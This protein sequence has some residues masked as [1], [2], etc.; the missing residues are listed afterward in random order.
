MLI[1]RGFTTDGTGE[2]LTPFPGSPG[3]GQSVDTDDQ[4]ATEVPYDNSGSGL[5]AND[6][7]E[8]IDELAAQV[9]ACCAETSGD[10]GGGDDLYQ[11]FTPFVFDDFTWQNQG[12][13]TFTEDPDGTG[14]MFGPRVGVAGVNIRQLLKDVPAAPFKVTIAIRPNMV[15]VN[16]QA[17]GLC[18]RQND[19]KIVTYAL[20][21][22]DS[23]LT[24]ERGHFNSETSFNAAANVEIGVA[25][26][27]IVYLQVEDDNTNR[28]FRYSNDGGKEFEELRRDARTTFITA[29]KFGIFVNTEN[30]G[31]DIGMR[32]YH[33]LEE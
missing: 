9:A 18:F 1:Q 11:P 30:T 29:T 20:Q 2:K 15:G 19:G 13:A 22:D 16:F 21:S 27:P 3:S 4:A 26:G 14:Y 23:K 25:L 32:I 24:F 5:G 17:C 28:I 7:Q 8:A 31:Q 6:V 10:G 12:G 33:W